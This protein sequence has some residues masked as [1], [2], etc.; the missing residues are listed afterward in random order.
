MTRGR[1]NG[2]ISLRH[3]CFVFFPSAASPRNKSQAFGH[4]SEQWAPVSGPLP[5]QGPERRRLHRHLPRPGA[6]DGHRPRNRPFV[7]PH[8][9]CFLSTLKGRDPE[10]AD[11]PPPSSGFRVP[12]NKKKAT[13]DPQ[14]SKMGTGFSRGFKI[15]NFASHIVSIIF[16][17]FQKFVYSLE[18]GTGTGPG[19][20]FFPPICFPY[21]M[22]GGRDAGE[23]P[24]L[25]FQ[26]SRGEK[27]PG[28]ELPLK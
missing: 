18:L 21:A 26:D 11:E 2:S 10:E 16:F 19:T 17:Y 14:S 28:D 27:A 6:L 1:L 5:L 25:R 22:L 9:I 7:F 15:G 8:P 13:G 24:P 23:P 3:H 4:I 20:G 12:E